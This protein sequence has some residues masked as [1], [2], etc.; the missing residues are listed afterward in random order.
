[1]RQLLYRILII[2]LNYLK[3]LR[4]DDISVPKA[5]IIALSDEAS[6]EDAIEIFRTSTVTRVP[7]YSDTLDNPLGLIHLKDFAL[8]H[9][10]GSSNMFDMKSLLPGDLLY[11]ECHNSRLTD[12]WVIH[13]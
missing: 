10:F 12:I 11:A 13:P 9:G 4:L 2:N 5:D 7:V 8:G 3:T 1:M 6:F